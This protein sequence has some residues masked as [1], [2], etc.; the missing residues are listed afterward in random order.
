MSSRF[1]FLSVLAVFALSSCLRDSNPSNFT[2]SPPTVQSLVGT[3]VPTVHTTELLKATG[4]YPASKSAITLKDDGG[5]TIDNV[6]DW[7]LTSYGEAKGKFDSG[8]GKWT[9][10]RNKGWWILMASFQTE[11]GQFSSPV[12]RTGNV[13]AMLSLVGQKPPY[14]L[15]LTVSDPN[16]DVTM[17]YEKQAE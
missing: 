2:T 1:P 11:S 16:A 15:Q 10:D 14:T 3:Y 17:Q 5:I 4:K 12:P 13:T 6:P 8:S 7:W 9:L